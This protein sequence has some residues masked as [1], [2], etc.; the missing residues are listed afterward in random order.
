MPRDNLYLAE[1]V[2]AIDRITRWLDG[3]DEHGWDGDEMRR[4]ASCSNSPRSAKLAAVSVTSCR[5][6]TWMCRG[7]G[8]QTS[9]TWRCTSTSP[10]SG[11]QRGGGVT[12][13]YLELPVQRGVTQEAGQPDDAV[14]DDVLDVAGVRPKRHQHTFA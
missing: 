13:V 1:I 7:D 8:S 4:A 3:I 9:G 11:R 12:L 2:E 5:N 6:G 10:L 14:D